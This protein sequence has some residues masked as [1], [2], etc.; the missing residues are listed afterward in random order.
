M[1]GLPDRRMTVTAAFPWRG[2]DYLVGVGFDRA[3]KAREIFL[4][5]TKSGS[6]QEALFTDG[7]ILASH[8]LQASDLSAADL[9]DKLSVDAADPGGPFR[10]PDAGSALAVALKQAAAIE[11]DAGAGIRDAYAAAERRVG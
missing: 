3:G 11:A 8:L 6:D 2:R 4:Q 7:A 9:F 5:G 1:S 10:K